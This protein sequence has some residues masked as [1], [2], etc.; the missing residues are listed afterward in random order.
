MIHFEDIIVTHA[1]KDNKANTAENAICFECFIILL[2]GL[3]V[4]YNVIQIL[5]GN[6]QNDD[7][8]CKK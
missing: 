5:T 6:E 1:G 7:D 4:M 8:P 2:L 3:D